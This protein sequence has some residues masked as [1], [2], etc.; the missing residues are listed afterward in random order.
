GTGTSSAMPVSTC[1]GYSYSQQIVL[2]SE[3]ANG[4]GGPGNITKIR[5][6]AEELIQ[7]VDVWTGWTIYLGHTAKT[8]FS[9]GTDFVPLTELTQVFSGTITPI[10][11]N[12]FEITFTTP[13]NYDGVSNIVVAVDEN[14][15]NDTCASDFCTYPATDRGIYARS[16]SSNPDPSTALSGFRT[17]TV[18]QIQFVGAPMPCAAPQGFSKNL[19]TISTSTFSWIQSS[20][21]ATNFDY[22]L[23]TEG[24]PESG[25][26]GLVSSGTVT[27]P[28]AT[29]SGLVL[30]QTYMLYVRSR[31]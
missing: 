2:A 6:H 14:T 23:R 31:C 27:S 17:S 22:E 7:L 3:Y 18:A 8:S 26:L 16:D 12:W 5:Y 28:S 11:E 20:N 1:W 30:G 21:D 4:S 10:E 24:A 25:S 19:S 15:P 13:F 29:V 9:S